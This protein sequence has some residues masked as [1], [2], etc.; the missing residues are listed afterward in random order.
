MKYSYF[1]KA[2]EAMEEVVVAV[3]ADMEAG[4]FALAT[5][6]IAAAPHMVSFIISLN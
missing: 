1:F 4:Q 3:A 6:Q 5:L 2:M